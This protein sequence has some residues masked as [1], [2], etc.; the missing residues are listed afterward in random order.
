MFFSV[1]PG[2]TWRARGKTSSKKSTIALLHEC[3]D[4][5][6]SGDRCLGFHSVLA[7]LANKT[8]IPLLNDWGP[9]MPLRAA[10]AVVVVVVEA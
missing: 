2:V 10:A 8:N 4:I 3:V 5:R 7:Q 9:V 1:V 6:G